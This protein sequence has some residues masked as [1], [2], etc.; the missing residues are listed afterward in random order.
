MC[1][2]RAQR[3]PPPPPAKNPL[4]CAQAWCA[5]FS[6]LYLALLPPPHFELYSKTSDICCVVLP[7]SVINAQS[8]QSRAS[9]PSHKR[10]TSQRSSSVVAEAVNVAPF[11]LFIYFYFWFCARSSSFLVLRNV[12][13]DCAR[14]ERHQQLSPVSGDF[15]HQILSHIVVRARVCVCEWS[16][17]V[18]V[19]GVIATQSAGAGEAR[20]CLSGPVFVGSVLRLCVGSCPRAQ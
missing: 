13:C 15:R 14:M 17:T 20:H 1:V 4:R 16:L 6:W 2:W 12:R 18:H 11:Y 19:L 7:L 10:W 5:V 8:A 3:P 9:F